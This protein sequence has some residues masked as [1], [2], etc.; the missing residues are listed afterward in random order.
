MT[1][2]LLPNYNTFASS[3][4]CSLKVLCWPRHTWR[5][6]LWDN[7]C[8]TV[9]LGCRWS[10]PDSSHSGHRRGICFSLLLVKTWWLIFWESLNQLSKRPSL[11][12]SSDYSPIGLSLCRIIY[13]DFLRYWYFVLLR[14]QGRAGSL[15]LWTWLWPLT[16]LDALAAILVPLLMVGKSLCCADHK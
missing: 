5:F 16:I 13:L 4:L 11:Y 1:K 3:H 9:L 6:I 8:M 7:L 10:E 12:D 14:F 15:V 2:V